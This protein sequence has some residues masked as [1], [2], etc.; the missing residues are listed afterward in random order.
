MS[1]KPV[2][3]YFAASGRAI[4]ARIALFAAFGKDGWIEENWDFT[5]FKAEKQKLA[6]KSPDARLV[7]GSLPQLT[8]P[9]GKTFCQSMSIAR[10]ACNMAQQNK[11][12]IKNLYPTHD[13]DLF[14]A[15]DE[16][17]GFAME[18]LDKCPQDPDD[19]AKKRKREEFSAETGF[20][21]KAMA[22][23]EKR[24]SEYPG[25]F[26][27]GAEPCIADFAIYGLNNM[28]AANFFDYVPGAYLEKFPCLLKHLDAVKNCEWMKKYEV[29][30]GKLP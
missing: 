14:F 6:E 15:M 18:I 16:S 29:A 28:I 1:G 22:V 20:M 3:L 21:G 27:L 12:D 7:S 13:G 8:T 2:F 30:Y 4:P 17:I 24:M 19:E 9:S 11:V 23:L 5:Q 26:L 10:W 25:D